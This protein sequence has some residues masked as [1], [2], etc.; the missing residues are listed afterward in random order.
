MGRKP[1]ARPMKGFSKIVFDDA[2]APAAV[3]CKACGQIRCFCTQDMQSG[4]PS[5]QGGSSSGAADRATTAKSVDNDKAA[6]ANSAATAK[7]VNSA[8]TAK[9]ANSDKAAKAARKAAK[10]ARRA[11]QAAA[12]Q[13]AARKAARRQRLEKKH[14]AALAA[15]PGEVSADFGAWKAARKAAREAAKAEAEAEEDDEGW[16]GGH[17]VEVMLEAALR[18][19][20][21]TVVPLRSEAEWR[22]ALRISAAQ[23]V[24]VDFTAAWRA[25]LGPQPALRVAAF[26][27]TRHLFPPRHRCGP[28]Q[29]IAPLFAR[30]CARH[31]DSALFVQVNV[32]ELEEVQ[33]EA[34]VTAMPTF[35]A[36]RGGKAVDEV[37]GGLAPALEALV[38]R[39]VASR[40]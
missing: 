11:A 26:A 15:A 7:A 20:Q 25:P 13:K 17:R 21:G 9:A 31:G 30:L 18:A 28:C 2:G 29:A 37:T 34:G 1:S 19:K 22:A 14:K 16:L 24:V 23:P 10:A 5:V 39:A 6:K 35:Q 27:H 33:A 32:D 40:Q 3:A 38:S 12:E 36:Y 4:C 8:S